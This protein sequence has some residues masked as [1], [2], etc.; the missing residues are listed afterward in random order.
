MIVSSLGFRVLFHTKRSRASRIIDTRYVRKGQAPGLRTSS[1]LIIRLRQAT[2]RGGRSYGEDVDIQNRWR[3]Y[4]RSRATRNGTPAN[5]KND[6][7]IA[8]LKSGG[9]GDP[10]NGFMRSW[11]R[12]TTRYRVSRQNTP[13][14]QLPSQTDLDDA[15]ADSANATIPFGASGSR[16]PPAGWRRT[17]D[18]WIWHRPRHPS[19][20]FHLA[21][22]LLFAA[23]VRRKDWPCLSPLKPAPPPAKE[24]SWQGKDQRKIRRWQLFWI[25][26]S[27]VVGDQASPAPVCDVGFTFFGIEV[28]GEQT[29]PSRPETCPRHASACEELQKTQSKS[30]LM[31]IDSDGR[32]GTEQSPEMVTS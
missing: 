23:S 1:C 20:C 27:D 21:Q 3:G 29:P 7:F 4:A 19:Q 13:T 12:S 25:D 2:F 31:T 10:A 22:H 16:S 17:G 6:P 32:L 11:A 9:W 30:L 14:R 5:A 26:V 15:L 28:I 18:T 24:R 8:P